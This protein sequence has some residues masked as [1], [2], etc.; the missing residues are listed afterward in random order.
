LILSEAGGN[1]SGFDHDD[2][3]TGTPWRRSV[4]AAL[5][6][7]LFTQWRDWVRANR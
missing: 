7:K 6:A 2:Y 5:D 1:M 4:I 3:W